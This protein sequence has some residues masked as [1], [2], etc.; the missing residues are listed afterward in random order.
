MKPVLTT[1]PLAAVAPGPSAAPPVRRIIKLGGA[2]VT[3]KSQLETLRPE[4]LDSL[5]RTLATTSGLPEAEAS[6]SGA[7]GTVLVHGAGSFG[8]FPAS[9][10][11]VVRGPISDPRVRRGFTLSRASV[12]KLNGL[13]VGALVAAGVPAVG[14][15]PLGLYHTCNK[16]VAVSGGASASAL[17]AAG[18]LPVLHGDCVLDTALGC[19]VLSGDT[20]VRDLA[21]RLRPQYVVFLTNVPGVYDRPPEEA[22]ARL[23]R[24]IMVTPD[25]G[26]RVAEVEGGSDGGDSGGGDSS[27]RMSV[28][29]HDATGGIALKVEEAAAVARMGIPV[30]IAQAGSEHGDAACR[31]GPQVAATAA[32]GEG[33]GE[34]EGGGVAAASGSPPATWRGTLVVLEGC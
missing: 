16:Q 1:Q 26:W 3:V 19:T 9:E 27:V 6:T 31:L 12:T 20:L 7:G 29:A 34:G 21:E 8:H 13:V 25:G 30:L 2:A 32:G 24:R 17:L 5:V 14:L 15:S 10:Y 4:V 23:L 33:G 11:G 28:D 18:L 22:G